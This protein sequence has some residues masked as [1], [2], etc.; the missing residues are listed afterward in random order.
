MLDLKIINGS[1][2]DG[3]GAPAFSAD[4]GIRGGRIVAIGKVDEAAK[5][6]L[7][8]TGKIVAPGFVDSH[9]H[10]DAQLFWDPYLSPS[11][12]HGVTTILG[13]NC[14]FSV[15]PLTPDAAAYLGPMLA[16]VEGMPLTTLQ[17]GVPWDW[18]SF[19]SY[20]DKL[21]GNVGVNCAFMA[22][23]SAIRRVVM[24]KRAVGHEAS[25][26]ELDK[27]KKMLADSIEQGAVGFST[28][29]AL[30]HNDADG[31]P[32]PSRFASRQEL[33]E[34]AAVCSRYEGT[35]VELLPDLNF[36]QDMIDLLTDFSLAA[37]RPVNWNVLYLLGS[38][39]AQVAE[40]Q[41]KLAA[42]EYA[43]SK[44]AVVVP[45][46]FV[47]APE[48]RINFWSGFVFDAFPD[49]APLFRL[50]PAE[51]IEKLKDPAYRRHL[52]ERANS[53][54][55]GMFRRTACWDQFRIDVVFAPENE[56]YRGR[57]VGEIAKEQGKTPFDT[58]IDI[59]IADGLKTSLRPPAGM[60]DRETYKHRAALWKNPDTV[61]GASDAGAHM[62]MIDTFAF[63]TTL[64]QKG[65]REHGVISLEEAV[66]ELTE[67]PAKLLGLRERGTI[68]QGWH[69]DIVVFDP[70]TVGRGD[71]YTRFDLPGDEG[72]LYADA[73]GVDH[74]MVN[75]TMIVRDGKHTENKPGTVLR[76]GRDTYTNK[77]PAAA[78]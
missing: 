24:G 25:Q 68:R 44:G 43:R 28:T 56:P 10:Y 15:A 3:T 29:V 1:V 12:Y 59:V 74:V 71:V 5:E 72:R 17:K 77:I 73:I 23:H 19:G 70:K 49:W 66:H 26:D 60:E 55:A 2:I 42:S 33:M 41:R 54:D 30:T 21:D 76:S 4:I 45:L 38:D 9:T 64:L 47:S 50:S 8:A 31:N 39:P 48:I 6:T 18:T 16:R 61:V 27:M 52:D 36:H 20:L 40:A 11:C 78:W 63:S 65:V 51:R 34:L 13:G 7:D 62:D 75:G 32:V 46:T 58:M 69:A 22:G 67:V 35:T 53:E 57:L 37:Q 14:G